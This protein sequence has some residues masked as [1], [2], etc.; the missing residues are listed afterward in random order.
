MSGSAVPARPPFSALPIDK[1]GPPGNAWGLYGPEDSLGAL[2]ILTPEVVAAAAAS[3]IKT[4]ERIS[5]DWR[6]DTPSHP[7]FGRQAFHWELVNRAGEGNSERTVNDDIVHFNTQS[8]SQW[9][10]FR[11]YGRLCV[12]GDC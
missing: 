7:S 2:N 4:G 3:E 11:H 10:G 8:S 5:L 6:L 1:N 9:D 12:S